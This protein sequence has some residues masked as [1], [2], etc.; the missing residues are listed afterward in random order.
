MFYF[1]Q[2]DT[3]GRGFVTE[4]MKHN[5]TYRTDITEYI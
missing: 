4:G 1:F 3:M 5:S 2:D